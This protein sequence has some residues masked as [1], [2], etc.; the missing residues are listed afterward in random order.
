M[1]ISDGVAIFLRLAN[2]S[3]IDRAVPAARPLAA[4][5]GNSSIVIDCRIAPPDRDDTRCKSSSVVR[6]ARNSFR[7]SGVSGCPCA[8]FARAEAVSSNS[9]SV[10]E[11]LSVQS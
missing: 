6:S 11:I 7:N 10:P 8:A 5:Q 2:S 3:A 9:S 4:D 1:A